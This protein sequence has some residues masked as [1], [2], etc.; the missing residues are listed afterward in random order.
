MYI[1]MAD[2]ILSG[3]MYGYCVFHFLTCGA[4]SAGLPEG[5]EDSGENHGDQSPGDQRHRHH[6]LSKSCA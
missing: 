3:D 5:G 2:F 4:I 6:P 1:K